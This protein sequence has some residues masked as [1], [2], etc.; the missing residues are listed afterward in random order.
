IGTDVSST[1]YVLAEYFVEG[2]A[3]NYQPVG[4]L[5]PD[6]V[7]TAA[8]TDTAHYKTRVVIWRPSR[9]S[10]FNGTVFVE[11]INVSPGFDSAVDWLCAPTTSFVR[12]RRGRDFTRGTRWRDD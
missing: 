12:E 3:R 8:A 10:D 7:W 6:G 11:W 5:T 4:T 9:P 2:R 1:G